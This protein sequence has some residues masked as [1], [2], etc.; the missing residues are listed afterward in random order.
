MKDWRSLDHNSGCTNLIA[1][2]CFSMRTFPYLIARNRFKV[3]LV[4][5]R[6]LRV[7]G[8]APLLNTLG[9]HS[10]LEVK[11]SRE[12]LD[13]YFLSCSFDGKESRVNRLCIDKQ[14]LA[15]LN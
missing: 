7:E 1:P 12:S 15:R 3:D 14:T 9:L 4:D 13:I 8:L 2:P 5:L 11:M 10:K 6:N